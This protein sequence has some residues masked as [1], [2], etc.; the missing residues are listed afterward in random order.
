M[1]RAMFSISLFAAFA[2]SL[3][4][5]AITTGVW[6]QFGFDAAG[7]G[8][9]GCSPADPGGAFCIP[10][11][12]TPTVFLDASP[13]T[14]ALPFGGKITVTDAFESGDSFEVLDFGAVLGLTPLVPQG[15]DCGDD[16][17]PCLA[18]AGMSHAT[19]AL[20]PGAHSFTIAP[21]SSPFGGGAAYF[22]VTAVP[23]PSTLF[24]ALAGALASPFVRRRTV[25]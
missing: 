25:R 21:I 4:A 14:I 16:P 1:R 9:T 11:S 12:G 17:M 22:L 24:L 18:N 19:L 20:A 10:S 23:E 7:V 13:W 15:V 6:Y 8:A 5:G 3:S 2:G